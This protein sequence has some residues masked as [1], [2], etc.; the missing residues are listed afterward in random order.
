MTQKLISLWENDRSGLINS[1][2]TSTFIIRSFPVLVPMIAW[3]NMRSFTFCGLLKTENVK[4][5]IHFPLVKVKMVH[6]DRK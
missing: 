5:G 1:A 2:L 6:L 4:Y 3:Q